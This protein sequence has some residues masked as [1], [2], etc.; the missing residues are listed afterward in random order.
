[1]LRSIRK[2]KTLAK[3][4][5][6]CYVVPVTYKYMSQEA[7]VKLQSQGDD[8]GVG[9]GHIRYTRKNKKIHK[10]RMEIKKYNPIA[11]KHTVYKE[12]K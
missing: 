4:Y 11:R 2:D 9:S 5:V 8:N 6:L 7:L 3:I 1:M 10:E 12:I